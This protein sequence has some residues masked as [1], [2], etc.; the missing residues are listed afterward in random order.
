MVTLEEL[1]RDV[2]RRKAQAEVD[3]SYRKRNQEKKELLRERR[4]LQTAK[5]RRVGGSIIAR[6]R[7]VGRAVG[8]GLA[9]AERKISTPPRRRPTRKAPV[10][11]TVR[12]RQPNW[13]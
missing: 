9:A 13:F 6:G 5:F 11:R 2:A 4:M 8:S 3:E 12:R 10:R 7:I 1:R